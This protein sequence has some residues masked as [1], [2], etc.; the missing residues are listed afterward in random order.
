MFWRYLSDYSGFE[1]FVSLPHTAFWQNFTYKKEE[2]IEM[3]RMNPQQVHNKSVK[4]NLFPKQEE[5]FSNLFT[6]EGFRTF[7]ET[8]ATTHE[9]MLLVASR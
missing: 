7:L 2:T 8:N 9:G 3:I 5:Y 1:L 6:E 4:R